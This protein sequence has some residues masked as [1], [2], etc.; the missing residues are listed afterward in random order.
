MRRAEDVDVA[1]HGSACSLATAAAED[2]A[3]P[4]LLATVRHALHSYRS[5][6]MLCTCYTVRSIFFSLTHLWFSSILTTSFL[7]PYMCSR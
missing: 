2:E 3:P 5:F 1:T 7:K 6:D 4:G